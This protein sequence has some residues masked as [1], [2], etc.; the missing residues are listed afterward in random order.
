MAAM[1]ADEKPYLKTACFQLARTV[2]VAD[3]PDVEQY[4]GPAAFVKI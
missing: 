4:G 3:D 1:L 2:F